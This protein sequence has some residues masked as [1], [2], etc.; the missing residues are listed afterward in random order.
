MNI[1]D[2]SPMWLQLVESL[3]FCFHFKYFWS[4]QLKYFRS[5]AINI[6]KE[7]W[8]F[9]IW[10]WHHIF[11]YKLLSLFPSQILVCAIA[12]SAQNSLFKI[13]N[14]RAFEKRKKKCVEIYRHKS[15]H[16]SRSSKSIDQLFMTN[17]KIYL[18]QSHIVFKI[19]PTE[20][21]LHT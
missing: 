17:L 6:L 21:Y 15:T 11:E 5:D 13:D 20:I 14:W 4:K 8:Q 3:L 18:Q 19:S 10:F 7:P 9:S 1:Y 16:V 2:L 12:F